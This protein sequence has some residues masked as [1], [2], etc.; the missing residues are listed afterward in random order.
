MFLPRCCFPGVLQDCDEVLL[1][2]DMES[3]GLSTKG[4]VRIP[5]GPGMGVK[6]TFPRRWTLKSVFL[7]WI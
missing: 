7:L 2:P 1:L 3:A 4:T 6:D 5:S